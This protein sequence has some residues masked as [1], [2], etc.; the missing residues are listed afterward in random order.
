MTTAGPTVGRL[1]T[2]AFATAVVAL[3]AIG[4]GAYVGLG[5]QQ[6]AQRRAGHAQLVLAEVGELGD[7]V[8]QADRAGRDPAAPRQRQDAEAMLDQTLTE[9]QR[10]TAGDPVQRRILAQVRVRAAAGDLE[11][12]AA[13][14]GAAHDHEAG[15]LD[16]LLR[17]SEATVRDTRWLIA[18]GV[19]GAV[20]LVVTAGWWSGR[21]IAAAAREVCA[22]ADR[23]VAGDLSRPAVVTGPAELTEAARALNATMSALSAAAAGRADARHALV[24]ADLVEEREEREVRGALAGP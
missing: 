17:R 8:N 12:A 10:L 11:R 7:R 5:A 3:G 2:A 16:E 21:R 24:E 19:A 6:D 23:I 20:L 14:V 13:L 4:A 9:A 1:L 15:R 18:A 22:A